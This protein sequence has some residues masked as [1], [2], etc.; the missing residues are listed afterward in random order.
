ME[1]LAADVIIYLAE[2]FLSDFDKIQLMMINKE[3]Y[4]L[5]FKFTFNDKVKY[6]L[7]N[8]LSYYDNFTNLI[9][10]NNRITLPKKI[11]YLTFSDFFNQLVKGFILNSVTH[12][13]FGTLFNQSIEDC[14]PNSVTCL[15]FSNS[16]N[17][18]IKDCIPN[19]VTHLTL[20]FNFNQPY[21]FKIS[22]PN[23]KIIIN[24]RFKIY[25]FEPY[26]K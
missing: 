9:I 23:I 5:R 21:N 26:F 22:H 17:Q 25:N 1:V 18:P 14:I 4:E 10:N 19:S 2:L 3:Y 13:T 8:H 24:D 11:K 6:K 16:F 15:T 12:L 20:G 7:V